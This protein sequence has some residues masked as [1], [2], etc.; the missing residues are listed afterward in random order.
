MKKTL[1]LILFG[2]LGCNSKS[3]TNT[4]ENEAII[5]KNPNY[6]TT[7][8][9]SKLKHGQVVSFYYSNEYTDTYPPFFISNKDSLQKIIIRYPTLI[10]DSRHQIPFLVYPGEKITVNVGT[11]N[12][13]RLSVD[14]NEERSNELN[15]FLALH[16]TKDPL[17]EQVPFFLGGRLNKMVVIK[18]FDYGEWNKN[19]NNI[20]NR[21]L[22][23]LN[24][25][26]SHFKTSKQFVEFTQ[27]FFKYV[28]YLQLITPIH[29]SNNDSLFL[30][31]TYYYTIDSLPKKFCCDSCVINPAYQWAVSNLLEY[32]G[33]DLRFNK[34]KLALLYDTTSKLFTGKTKRFVHFIQLKR[35]MNLMPQNYKEVLDTFKKKGKDIYSAYLLENEALFDSSIVDN[36]NLLLDAHD[37]KTSWS[38]LIKKHKGNIIYVDFWASWCVPCRK[39]IPY[40]IGL[41]NIL[42]DKNFLVIFIS[43]DDGISKWKNA[44]KENGIDSKNSFI[45]PNWKTSEIVNRF[46]IN[47]I[48]RYLLIGKNGQI[49]SDHA[50]SPE[51][52]NLKEIIEKMER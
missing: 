4:I 19:A 12:F 3:Q 38:D 17:F 5:Q 23:F 31:K 7:I 43:I 29:F 11:D 45:I 2:I 46:K 30:P 16:K 40:S 48:P 28:Y 34:R 21:R 14:G 52:K 13:S 8:F 20:Y 36:R 10:V 18:R 32:F 41:G 39:E 9:K 35:N 15:F 27:T 33:R 51:N 37:N 50:P 42:M 24:D 1:I 26:V 49:I 44:M 22:K 47:L 6:D 25:Y